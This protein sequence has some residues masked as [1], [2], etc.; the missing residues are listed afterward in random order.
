MPVITDPTELRAAI[1]TA[2]AGMREP[3]YIK[4][5]QQSKILV[6]NGHYLSRFVLNIKGSLSAIHLPC[7][8]STAKLKTN[9]SLLRAPILHPQRRKILQGLWNVEDL[10][11][12]IRSLYVHEALHEAAR[13]AGYEVVNLKASLGIK[14]KNSATQ[15]TILRCES[16]SKFHN[17]TWH[18]TS[19]EVNTTKTASLSQ[20]Q[21]PVFPSA[22]ERMTFAETLLY[23]LISANKPN[24]SKPVTYWHY[25]PFNL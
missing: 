15:P 22:D 10:P 21:E 1:I 24:A 16:G 17:S 20:T 12:I 8:G 23:T 2:T 25:D 6:V 11:A 18:L 4:E 13:K 3:F 5:I 7:L 9:P 19:G 14:L